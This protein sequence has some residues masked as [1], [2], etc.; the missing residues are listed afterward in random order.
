MSPPLV[1][2]VYPISIGRNVSLINVW[3]KFCELA[4]LQRVGFHKTHSGKEEIT[5]SV[6]L[7]RG[8]SKWSFFSSLPSKGECFS[9]AFNCNCL[10]PVF[11]PSSVQCFQKQRNMAMLALACGRKNAYFLLGGRSNC[12]CIS[13]AFPSSW[14][15]P[16][17][18]GHWCHFLSTCSCICFSI[19][20]S[21]YIVL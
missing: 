15:K 21:T 6:F 2:K 4:N 20:Y 13:R 14:S 7:F 10:V 12:N 16:F 11:S 8:A 18:Q 3:E 19:F 17:S 5:S 9:L 1:L